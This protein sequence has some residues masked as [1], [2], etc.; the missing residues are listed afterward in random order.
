M[1]KM[2]IFLKFR[3][4]DEERKIIYRVL[5]TCFVLCKNLIFK[6][7]KPRIDMTLDWLDVDYTMMYAFDFQKLSSKLFQSATVSYLSDHLNL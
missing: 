6:F 1:I 2:Y 4:L 7:V 3:R 5:Q